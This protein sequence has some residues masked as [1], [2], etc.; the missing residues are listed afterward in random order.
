MWFPA[1]Q[2]RSVFAHRVRR[3]RRGRAPRMLV[4]KRC[5]G[6]GPVGPPGQLGKDSSDRLVEAAALLDDFLL[7]RRE[8]V[9]LP[10]PLAHLLWCEL[11]GRRPC[12]VTAYGLSE[13]D[14]EVVMPGRAEMFS[15]QRLQLPPRCTARPAWISPSPSTVTSEH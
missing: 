13:R 11:L 7:D 8:Q 10:I 2:V 1:G 4:E 5:S 12:G 6:V 3:Y 9:A 14:V 15:G